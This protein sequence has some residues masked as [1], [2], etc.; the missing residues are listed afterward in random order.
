MAVLGD[1]GQQRGLARGHGLAE[2]GEDVRA[3]LGAVDVQ[4]AADQRARAP[5]H[6]HPQGA[7]QDADEHADQPAGG[8][9]GSASS[10][11]LLG[12]GQVPVRGAPDD[13]GAHEVQAA[14]VGGLAQLA[15]RLVRLGLLGEGDGDDVGVCHNE[16]PCLLVVR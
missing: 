2:L 10:V 15:E 4:Q 9:P 12:D 16:A 3:A 7:A 5:A 6:E 8:G 1:L 14:R 13:G 11:L